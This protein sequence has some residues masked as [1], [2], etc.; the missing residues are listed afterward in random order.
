MDL[1]A[2]S[3]YLGIDVVLLDCLSHLW[4]AEQ[5]QQYGRENVTLYC[6]LKSVD[7][8]IQIPEVDTSVL[9]QD[10]ESFELPIDSFRKSYN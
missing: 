7:F 9:N 10:V 1:T 8:F 2:H 6:N 5:C 3:H 4:Q